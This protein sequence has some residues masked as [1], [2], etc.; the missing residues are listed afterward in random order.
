MCE[1]NISLKIIKILD[2]RCKMIFGYGLCS[3]RC[4]AV[5]VL[6]SKW[7]LI[8]LRAEHDA[9]SHFWGTNKKLKSGFMLKNASV[10]N[11]VCPGLKIALPTSRGRSHFPFAN[12]LFRL[13]SL[14]LRFM[15]WL[16][17]PS[18][19]LSFSS[20][21]PPPLPISTCPPRLRRVLHLHLVLLKVSSC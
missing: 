8:R 6:S 3:S 19:F 13:W 15:A 4:Q 5:M 2:F 17:P 7:R 1:S 21:W 20:F 16:V 11:A 12:V 9:V 10:N 14:L 18:L